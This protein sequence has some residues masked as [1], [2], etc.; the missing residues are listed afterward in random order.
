[1]NDTKKRYTEKSMLPADGDVN[2]FLDDII[3]F[4]II[5][6]QQKELGHGYGY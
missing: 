6:Q 5:L 2:I 3:L 4:S 1:M